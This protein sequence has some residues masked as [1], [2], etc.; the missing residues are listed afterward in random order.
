MKL[1]GKQGNNNF[2]SAEKGLRIVI[3][4]NK[5]TCMSVLG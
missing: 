5:G 1:L 2:K 3:Y 4:R